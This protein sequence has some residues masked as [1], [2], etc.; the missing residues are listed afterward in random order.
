[1]QRRRHTVAPQTLLLPERSAAFALHAFASAITWPALAPCL[2]RALRFEG[3]HSLRDAT[4]VGIAA[5][6]I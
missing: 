5:A 4:V 1:M 2:A 6:K 3:R